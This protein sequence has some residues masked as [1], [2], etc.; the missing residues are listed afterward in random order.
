MVFIIELP[1]VKSSPQRR[2]LSCQVTILEDDA[3]PLLSAEDA[4]EITEYLNGLIVPLFHLRIKIANVE[5][6]NHYE[7]CNAFKDYINLSILR[8]PRIDIFEI[9]RVILGK[10]VSSF[11]EVEVGYINQHGKYKYNQSEIIDLYMSNLSMILK[12]AN[13]YGNII[14]RKENFYNY[15]ISYLNNVAYMYKPPHKG[16]NLILTNTPIIEDVE[17]M[18]V[19][20]FIRGGLING[21]SPKNGKTIFLSYFPIYYK[22]ALFQNADDNFQEKKNLVVAYLLAHE[23]GHAY[24]NL[25]DEYTDKSSIMYPVYKFEYLSWI[26]NI[27][28]SHI[29]TH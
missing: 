18:P 27:K 9:N 14:V 21:F 25:S 5:R 12:L 6:Y 23:I 20:T 8:E 24:F 19:H 11:N 7:F 4:I 17:S 13:K 1:E 26:N 3:L 28:I 10:I 29:A 15:S 16:I 22:T 2:T